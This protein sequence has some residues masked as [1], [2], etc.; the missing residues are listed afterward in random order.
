VTASSADPRTI[1]GLAAGRRAYGNLKDE[2]VDV[3][4]RAVVSGH[5]PPGAKIDQD[6]IA[7]AL[8]ISRAPVREALVELAQKGFVLAV[9]RRGAFVAEVTAED[10]RD[11]YAVVAQVSG[12]TT[13][14]AVEKLTPAD[15][16]DLRRLHREIGASADPQRRKQLDRRFFNVVASAGRSPRLDSILV[17]LGGALQGSFYLESP[18]WVGND[19]KYRGLL[20]DAIGAGDVPAAVRVTEEHLRSCAELTVEHLRARGYWTAAT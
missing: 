10:I 17:F 16:D 8:G 1:Y 6:E 19:E 5:L 11:H 4:R 9:P 2:A 13:R 12:M 14:R 15:V 3:I 18:G 7:E 20:L